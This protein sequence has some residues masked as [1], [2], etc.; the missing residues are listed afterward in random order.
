MGD[1][2]IFDKVE[3]K[4]EVKRKPTQPWR[5]ANLLD[6]ASRYKKKVEGI[7]RLRWVR[8]DQVEKKLAEGWEIVKESPEEISPEKTIID[9]SPID[10]VVRK[11]GLILCR[12]PEDMA[13]ARAEYFSKL[14]D[15]SVKEHEKRFKDEVTVDGKSLGSGEIKVK[16]GGT[17]G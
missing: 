1:T 9:G 11:R 12:M 13:K 6:A 5:P 2:D 14:T 16:Q 10:G 7:F 17:D 3:K 8:K 15:T 4:V